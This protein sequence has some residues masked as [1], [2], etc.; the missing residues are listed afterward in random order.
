MPFKFARLLNLS[1]NKLL[2]GNKDRIT[3]WES[4]YM[5]NLDPKIRNKTQEWHTHTHTH[6][7][8]EV[9]TPL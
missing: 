3:L 9:V 7:H 4:T 6:T 8:T 1:L 5:E 2:R